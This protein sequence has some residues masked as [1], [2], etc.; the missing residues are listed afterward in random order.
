MRS[1]R[2]REN[3]GLTLV[4]TREIGNAFVLTIVEQLTACPLEYQ[5]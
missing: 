5:V 2:V 4:G 3:Q 1:V